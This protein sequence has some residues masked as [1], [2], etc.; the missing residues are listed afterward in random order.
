MA[1]IS[2][3]DN[4]KRPSDHDHIAST[5]ATCQHCGRRLTAETAVQTLER[6][7][8]T[9]FEYHMRPYTQVETGLAM[10]MWLCAPCADGM[11]MLRWYPADDAATPDA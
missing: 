8:G 9:F 2:W 7:A 1:V 4:Y 3:N 11:D 10:R 6:P 5:D